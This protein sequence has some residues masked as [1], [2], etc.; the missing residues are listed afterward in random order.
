MTKQSPE[1]CATCGASF[2]WPDDGVEATMENNAY[3]QL[4]RHVDAEH[5]SSRFVCP[6]QGENLI[7]GNDGPRAHWN[8]NGECSYCGSFSEAKFFEAV[9]A[10]AEIRPTDKN[11]KA[12][13]GGEGTPAHSGAAKFYFQHLSEA[14]KD[15]FI[16]MLNSKAMKLGYPGHFYA[17]PYFVTRARTLEEK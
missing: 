8:P 9:E 6:R 16:A 5:P 3:W 1:V 13:V 7:R 4:T 11:Y 12:Y 2:E 14:G 10:G 15:R 17:L